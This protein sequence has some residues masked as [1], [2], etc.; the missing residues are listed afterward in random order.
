[1]GKTQYKLDIKEL[2]RENIPSSSI[3]EIHTEPTQFEFTF[4]PQLVAG[5]SGR[6]TESPPIVPTRS[7][8][9]ETEGDHV[10]IVQ[11]PLGAEDENE[12]HREQELVGEQEPI[13]IIQEPPLV[14]RSG[15]VIRP[16]SRYFLCGESFAAVSTEQEEDPTSA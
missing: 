11:T 12:G 3:P 10:P 8:I 9:P 5:S 15:R 4:L 13:P 2:S 14:R 1:M 6:Q 16:P 7:P